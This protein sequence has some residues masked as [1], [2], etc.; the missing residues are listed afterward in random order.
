M[1]YFLNS[2]PYICSNQKRRAF[3]LQANIVAR[4]VAG[5]TLDALRLEAE[6]LRRE[7]NTDLRQT[8]IY[9]THMHG[10]R[11]EEIAHYGDYTVEY[12]E[13]CI[14]YKDRIEYSRRTG[15]A[16]IIQWPEAEE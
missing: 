4:R 15:N 2:S 6:A 16:I 10:L 8:G 14:R 9:E 13:R 11:A 5:T 7:L 3:E 12:V 1:D